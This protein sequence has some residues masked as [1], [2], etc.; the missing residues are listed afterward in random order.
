MKIKREIINIYD[1]IISTLK[2]YT[3]EK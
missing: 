2:D 1:A 3:D